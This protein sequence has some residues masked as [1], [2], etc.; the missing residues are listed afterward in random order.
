[1]LETDKKCQSK[2]HHSQEQEQNIYLLNSISSNRK[3]QE[4]NVNDPL[5]DRKID[6]VAGGLAPYYSNLLHKRKMC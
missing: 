5:L 6:G 1:M 2:Y 4:H 3:Q